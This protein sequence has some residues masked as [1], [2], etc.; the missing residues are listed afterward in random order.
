MRDL[1]TGEHF[2]YYVV[3]HTK[4]WFHHHRM[5][6]AQDHQSVKLGSM[7]D[8]ET[9]SRE[10]KLDIGSAVVDFVED[11]GD[12]IEVNEVKKSK[13][14]E[15]AHKLQLS[16]YMSILRPENEEVQMR[17]VI[18]YP[19]ESDTVE[20]TLDS[21]KKE[22]EDAKKEIHNIINGDMPTIEWKQPCK[23]CSMREFCHS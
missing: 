10:Q 1:L 7:V 2:E 14:L 18:R 21:Y 13:K 15:R 11:K 16:H 20:F 19:K 6:Y 23:K 17:G 22:Y 4:L 3:C 8:D 12:V 5:I 9:Y